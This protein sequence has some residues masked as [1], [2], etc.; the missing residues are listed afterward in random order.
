MWVDIYHLLKMHGESKRATASGLR[1]ICYTSPTSFLQDRCT[2]RLWNKRRI[3]EKKS[4]LLAH[5]D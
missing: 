2:R 1:G 4:F 3:R 5:C